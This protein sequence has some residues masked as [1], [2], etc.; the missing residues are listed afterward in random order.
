[1]EHGCAIIIATK[2]LHLTWTYSL[3]KL[4]R[5]ECIFAMARLHNSSATFNHHFLSCQWSIGEKQ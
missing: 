5:K 2:A 4:S 3:G 1:M